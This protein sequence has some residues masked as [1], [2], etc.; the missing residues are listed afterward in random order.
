MRHPVRFTGLTPDRMPLP[1]PQRAA[2]EPS[3]HCRVAGPALWPG[4]LPRMATIH[5]AEG[6]L[7][8]EGQDDNLTV[9]AAGRGAVLVTLDRQ[10]IQRR[11]ANSIERHVRLRCAEPTQLDEPLALGRLRTPLGPLLHPTRRRQH[12]PQDL[13][14]CL[15]TQ[16]ALGWRARRR[17][18]T[19]IMA[20]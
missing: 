17:V 4:A 11:R 16:A 7:A 10:F 18:M 6:G 2:Q 13:R 20:Q 5:A 15:R 19:M 9:Y 14:A 1:G 12:N 8:A 3:G